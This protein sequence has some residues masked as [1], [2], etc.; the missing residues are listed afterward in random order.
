MK[1]FRD[2]LKSDGVYVFDGAVGTRLYDKGVYINRSYDELN[3][4][5]AD[6]VRE[7]HEE[8]VK[9]GADVIETNSF[10][11]TRHKLQPYGLETKIREINIAAAR[12]ARE[13]AGD[14]VFVAGAIGPL[15]LRIE[16][17]GPTSFDEA[18][19]LFKEQVEGLLEGGVD[20]FILETF[21]ELP[22]IEQAIRAVRELSDLPIVTQMTIQMDGKT[23][24]GT[25]PEQFTA[26]LD[27]LGAD[28]I[29]LNCG[30]GPTHVLHALE[31]MRAVTTK[32]LTAQP[33]AGLPRD[34]Q[35]RQFYMGS[36]EYMAT[37][38]KRFVQAGA[39]FVGGCCGTTPTHIKLI[40]DAIR[41]I[42]PRQ[43]QVFAKSSPAK[44]L[45]LKPVDI[46]VVPAE[47]RSKWGRKIA[48]GEFVTSVEVLPPKGCD[49]DK[50]LDSIRLLKDAG[51]DGVNI[52]D[53]P[54]AQTRMS[55]QATAVLV[56]R[57]IGIEAV[58]HYC[59]RDRNLLGM[60]SDLLGAAALGL[61]NL[62]IITGD[63]PKMGPYPDATAVFDIDAIG[64]T[65]MVNKLNHGLDIGNNPIGK[66]T[67]FSIGVGVNPGAVNL[68]EEIRRFEWKVEAG[69]EYA[70]TQP[71]FDTAQL[72]TFLE[73]IAHVKIPIIAGIW[74]LVSF[75]NAEFLHNE[76]PGVNVTPEI[77]ERMRIASEQ[78]KEEAREE[79]IAIARESL[80]EVRDIIQGVQVSAPF[81]NVKYALQVFDALPEF[82]ATKTSRQVEAV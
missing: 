4:V 53:G 22:V 5:A 49:A 25:T 76:V 50:T 80:I 1:N 81:G 39:K 68:E 31:T 29:G 41:S 23:T 65:N 47:E 37:F 15:G 57:E 69:A 26:R 6:L 54:R 44:V 21:S 38:A 77:L 10:G 67:A 52:P 79:G 34:V 35:G 20:L 17:F 78:G 16:P 63:P 7:V 73:K 70:I 19:D 46:Q 24:F 60:M 8:Y 51:V 59:C 36:P 32:P 40:A 64:L 56:E 71:V 9:A 55:A 62:L 18:K 12:I 58:L 48:H 3:L 13:A 75:R 11:A 14:R 43:A 45:D 30:M 82:G 61:H 42:S 27:E 74:P 2:I 72:R 33:N 66:P 28:V